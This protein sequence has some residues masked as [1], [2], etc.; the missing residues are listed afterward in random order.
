MLRNMICKNACRFFN[1]WIQNRHVRM[2]LA[3]MKNEP[4]RDNKG[5]RIIL[6]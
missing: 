4:N 2:S 3:V 1:K 6:M 5:Q